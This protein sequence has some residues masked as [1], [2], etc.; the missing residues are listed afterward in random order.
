MFAAQARKLGAT[1]WRRAQGPQV[2]SGQPQ[3]TSE[4]QSTTLHFQLNP[5][6]MIADRLQIV[7][8]GD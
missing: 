4:A 5:S 2:S 8:V 6:H 3:G 7:V 1:R